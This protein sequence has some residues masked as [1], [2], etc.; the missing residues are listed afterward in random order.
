MYKNLLYKLLT[1]FSP[2][3]DKYLSKKYSN[4]R[5]L[6]IVDI[7]FF[8]GSFSKS[9]ITKVLKI[10]KEVNISLYS[11]DPNSNVNLD[12]FKEFWESRNLAK[13]SNWWWIKKEHISPPDHQLKI[14]CKIHFGIKHEKYF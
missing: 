11:F 5:N 7:G 6:N 1:F 12:T 3:F 4:S 8:K 2:N 9:L 14:F 13:H 10:N